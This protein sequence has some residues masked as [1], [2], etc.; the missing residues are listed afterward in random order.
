M[1]LLS[2]LLL[3]VPVTAVAAVTAAAP[4]AIII[5]IITVMVFGLVCSF[6]FT[7]V[8][9]PLDNHMTNINLVRLLINKTLVGSLNFIF[10]S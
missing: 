3:L 8:G 2:L 1:Q 9:P 10:V 6:H 4:A 5:I 7:A